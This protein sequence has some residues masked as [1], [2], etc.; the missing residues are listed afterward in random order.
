[1]HLTTP[2]PPVSTL[3]PEF[4]PGLGEVIAHALQKE[5]GERFPT[6]EAM[7][8]AIGMLQLRSREV[9]PLLRLFHQQTAQSLQTILMLVVIFAIFVQFSGRA[10]TLF[11]SVLFVLFVTMGVTVLLQTLDR[12][13]FTVRQGFTVDDVR[14]AIGAMR[15]ETARAREQLLADPVERRRIQRRKRFAMFGGAVAGAQ[16][17][18]I[19]KLLARRLDGT[20]EIPAVGVLLLLA[21]TVVSGISLALWASRPVRVTLAQST[22]QRLWGSAFGGWLFARAARRYA[23]ELR[24]LAT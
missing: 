16:M 10:S 4:P 1:M 20:T 3:R 21:I 17:P 15:D 7:A 2:A 13:R 9:A 22:A 19:P 24:R 11:G 23:R 6:G 14:S 12:V 5:P 8:D 18:L